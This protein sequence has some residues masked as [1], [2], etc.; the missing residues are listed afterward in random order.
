MGDVIMTTPALRALKETFGAHITLLTSSMAYRIAPYIP[1]VDDVIV[2]NLPW[3]KAGDALDAQE[4]KQLAVTLQNSNFDAAVI[5]TVYSQSALPAALLA[6]LAGI[7]KRLAYSRENPYT[8]LTHWVPDP[9]PYRFIQH[10]VERDLKL[11]NSIGATTDNDHLIVQA[12]SSSIDSV[13]YKI[14]EAG[15]TLPGSYLLLHPGVS[16]IKRQY[17]EIYWIETGRLLAKWN[18]PLLITGTKAEQPLAERITQA[19]GPGA[20]NMAGLLEVGEF[21]A[22]ISQ[23]ALVITVNTATVH[24]AAAT[25][26]P[27]VVLYARTNPQHTPWQVPAKVFYFNVE[28]TIRSK[29]E[30]VSY[31]HDQLYRDVIEMPSSAEIAA[32]AKG[33]LNI[34]TKKNMR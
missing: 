26:T 34:A 9:E 31:V 10:Q 4:I 12:D 15:I 23:A 2:A 24:I 8:L 33:L 27:I 11:V 21:I 18:I 19:I 28:E 1:Y 30:V 14:Q 32:A 3:V 20:Y 16:E 29:N 25:Q 5:F 22:L 17:P 7:P 13:R 6:M